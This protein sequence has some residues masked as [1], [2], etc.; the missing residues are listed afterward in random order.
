MYLRG[1]AWQPDGKGLVYA[2]SRAPSQD[3]RL[4]RV[5]LIPGAAP[6]RLDLAGA[7]VRHPAVSSAGHLLAFTHLGSWSLLLIRNFR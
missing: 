2:A 4:W 6:E 3:T 7:R 1:L 5:G